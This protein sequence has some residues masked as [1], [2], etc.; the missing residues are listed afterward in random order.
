MFGD[1]SNDPL[2]LAERNRDAAELTDRVELRRGDLFGAV[3]PGERF[4]VVVSNPPYVPETEAEHLQ[5]EVVEWEPRHALFAGADGLAV[6]RL[7]TAGAIDVLRPEGLLA[8]EVGAGQAGAV[9]ELLEAT[10]RYRG[11]EVKRDYARKERIVMARC[12]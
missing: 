11:V 6:L 4:D 1:P 5:P 7:L 9:A 2:P 3:A 12:A 8:L 10:D